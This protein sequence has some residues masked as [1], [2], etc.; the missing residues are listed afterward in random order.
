KNYV[1]E[2]GRSSKV[3]HTN[4]ANEKEHTSVA[5]VQKKATDNK[6]QHQENYSET[7]AYGS[8]LKSQSHMSARNIDR[9][10]QEGQDAFHAGN[11]AGAKQKALLAIAGI[12]IEKERL[13]TGKNTDINEQQLGDW[14]GG[15]SFIMNKIGENVTATK[16][17]YTA[18]VFDPSWDVISHINVSNV[19]WTSLVFS[20]DIDD[21][22]SEYKGL[23]RL[24]IEIDDLAKLAESRGKW[25][26]CVAADCDINKIFSYL[27]RQGHADSVLIK[28]P[29]REASLWR[30]ARCFLRMGMQENARKLCSTIF[31][32][33]CDYDDPEAFEIWAFSLYA[34]KDFDLALEKCELALNYCKDKNYRQRLEAFRSEIQKQIA[35]NTRPEQNGKAGNTGVNSTSANFKI[36]D[37]V[38]GFDRVISLHRAKTLNAI[39]NMAMNSVW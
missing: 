2:K 30:S 1:L 33:A 26:V 17:F 14:Y 35:V 10:I 21:L 32:H 9:L 24:L 20:K 27:M 37:F 39:R 3:D 29:G 31:Q 25:N 34:T 28:Q 6:I 19:L 4:F 36:K 16:C 15:C 12:N 11:N 22:S 7:K 23:R 5:D 13:L 38:P 8:D 18:I